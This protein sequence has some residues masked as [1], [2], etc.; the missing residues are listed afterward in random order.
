VTKRYLVQGPGDTKWS[1]W[2]SGTDMEVC[3]GP[4]LTDPTAALIREPIG[5][6]LNTSDRWAQVVAAASA[7]HVAKLAGWETPIFLGL[8]S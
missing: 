1:I 6:R 3:R 2:D 5:R 7:I 4:E 8:W